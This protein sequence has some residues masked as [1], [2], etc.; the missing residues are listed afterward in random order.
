MSLHPS[1]QP[2]FD[3][4]LHRNPGESEF[5]QAVQE[6]LHSL[7]PV[8][9]KHPEYLEL[10]TFERLCEPER[11]I[12]FRVPWID[13]QG[14]VQINRAFRVQ[15]NS[16]LGP[17]KGGLRFHPSVN[18]GIVKF[19]GFEQIFKN[20]ITGLPIGGGK[21]GSDFDPKGRSDLEVMRFCQS[22]MTELSRHIGEYRDV[23]AG[24]IGV[25]G[26]EIGYLF[27]QYKRMK[28]EYE[29]GVLTGKGLSYGGS[30][31]RTEATGFGVVYFLKDML[32]AA[33][34]NIDGRTVSISGS[35][36][37]AVFAAEKATAFGGTVITMSDSSG[38]IHDPDGIDT[39]IVKRIKFE[40]RGRISD[41][42]DERGGRAT[43]HEGGNVWE[44]E[45]DVALP[46][47]TQ[48]E[49]DADSARTLVR[50][51]VIA[52]AEGANMP[53]TP[54]AVKTFSDAG[55]LFAP[56]KAANAGGVATSALEMQQNAS[57]DTWDFDFTEARLAEIMGDVHDS[58]AAAA[59]EFGSPG[60]YV[61]G[62][63]IA[64]FIRVSEAMLAQ[65]VV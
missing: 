48:N 17:Y 6:V 4:V 26:R 45:V 59:A 49:L 63:N 38:F 27:G 65:G 29:A 3:T 15:F 21:G 44:I 36:N 35:G 51:G 14:V 20:A 24:D 40:E 7:G 30:M 11:Q 58:C 25:G 9:D 46:C 23:P 55:V 32:A 19:L 64:G 34:K 53:C 28:N 13:D 1:L 18:L 41:Y 52:L 60:D 62:A 43:Y 33:K 37:V 12:I 56:G 31:V 61:A 10:S 54:E 47:A 22:F 50:N 5:H 57:R 42:V 2:I 16:A 39:D 8:V